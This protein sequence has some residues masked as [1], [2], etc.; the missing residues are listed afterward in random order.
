[1]GLFYKT[2]NLI[3]AEK[4]LEK[5]IQHNPNWPEAYSNLGIILKDLGKL[6]KA[7]LFIKKAI[8]LNPNSAVAYSNLGNILR[9]LKKFKEAEIALKKAI[10]LDPKSMIGYANLGNM[11]KGLGRL[12]EAKI[13]LLKT[14]K[15]NPEFVRPYYSLSKFANDI[16]DKYWHNYLFS[17]KFLDKKTEKEQI[18][19]Y[20]ARSNLLHKEKNLM[21]A[22]RICNL[23][24]I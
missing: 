16:S 10:E 9:K 4:M 14:I 22:P 21:K 3:E 18:D 8:E 11:L 6:T 13:F 17:N 19:I 7:E 15:I 23:L 20:F 1:M 24:I 2:S 5:S 12:N